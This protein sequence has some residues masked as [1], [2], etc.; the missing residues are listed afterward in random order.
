MVVR[1]PGNTDIIYRL[2]EVHCWNWKR[3]FYCVER[4]NYIDEHTI[5]PVLEEIAEISKMLGSLI[6]K[7]S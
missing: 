1:R 3:S 7:L 6:S 5:N 2:V 4:L